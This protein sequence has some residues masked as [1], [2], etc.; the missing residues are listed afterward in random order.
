MVIFMQTLSMYRE[1]ASILMEGTNDSLHDVMAVLEDAESP[2]NKKYREKLY[3]NII[4][5]KHVDF[6]DIPKSKGDITKYSGYET[7]KETLDVLI[8]LGRDEKCNDLIK[9]STVVVTAI[10]NIKKLKNIYMKAYSR[11]NEYVTLDYQLYVYT[12]VEATTSLIA[13]F[14][15]D[16]K[17]P[18]SEMKIVLK[19]T[20]FRG[21]LFFIQSL[22]QFNRVNENNKYSSFLMATLTNG[23]ENLLG[24]IV[25]GTSISSLAL[26]TGAIVLIA[27]SIIPVTRKLIYYYK[28]LKR[29]LS[30]TLST[31]AYFLEMNKACIEYNSTIDPKKKKKILQKQEKLRKV[32]LSL[33]DRLKVTDTWAERESGK[34]IQNDNKTMSMDNIRDEVSDSD[35]VIM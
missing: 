16:I 28:E 8:A 20:R 4:D 9:Y 15:N 33:S 14:V 35:I 25:A 19:D 22:M 13:A 30:E 7:M 11:K 18:S 24:E 1:A 31:Q 34:K 5:R 29:K 21:N 23:Q 26:G 27:L 12:C 10:E 3:Q 32:F 17:T 6:G 2:I